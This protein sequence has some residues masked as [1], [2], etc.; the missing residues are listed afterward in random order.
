MTPLFP[1]PRRCAHPAI[2]AAKQ[3]RTAM[4]LANAG[5][6]RAAETLLRA[7][8]TGLRGTDMPMMQAKILNSLGLVYLQRER[9]ETARRCLARALTLIERKIGRDNWLYKSVCG[10]RDSL[11]A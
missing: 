4:D 2:K 10:N 9:P 3:C 7:A 5:Q 11:A 8:M 1:M 6:I